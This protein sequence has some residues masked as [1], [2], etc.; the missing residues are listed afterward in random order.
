MR[1]GQQVRSA[2]TP[3]AWAGR[4]SRTRAAE[5]D[6]G[7][8]RGQRA[9]CITARPHTAAPAARLPTRCCCC[10][11]CCCCFL[12]AR[13]PPLLTRA[14]H[15]CHDGGVVERVAN[16]Q[17]TPARQQRDEG[18][19]GGKA[20][21][22]RDGRLLALQRLRRWHAGRHRG[23][24]GCGAGRGR[25][26][27]WCVPAAQNSP[28]PTKHQHTRRSAPRDTHRHTH[29]HARTRPATHQE[30]GHQP[31]QLRM[32]RRG[33][34]VGARRRGGPAQAVQHGL[35]PRGAVLVLGCSRGSARD[36]QRGGRLGWRGTAGR[37]LRG[38]RTGAGWRRKQGASRE[39]LLAA[40]AKPR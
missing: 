7:A 8:R 35:H 26:G 38:R 28:P 22:A 17:R 32:A 33:A 21:A 15:P 27:R 29:T 19:V 40:P 6:G 3:A 37:E 11:Y 1:Y 2:A 4:T 23:E 30:L 36:G 39:T 13:D 34:A 25:A 31:L 12:R 18:G 16:H 9:P 5:R 20:H 24:A 14:A 10:Y